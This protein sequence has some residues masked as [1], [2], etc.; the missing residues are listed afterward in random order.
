MAEVQSTIRYINEEKKEEEGSTFL[1]DGSESIR[2]L[3]SL[4][5]LNI[6]LGIKLLTHNTKNNLMMSFCYILR[7]C[8]EKT[9]RM[10]MRALQ[11]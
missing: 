9:R 4:Y 1:D 3:Y 7:K 10:I 11:R 8:I 5:S 6:I 2:L